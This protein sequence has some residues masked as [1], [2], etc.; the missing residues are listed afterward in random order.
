MQKHLLCCSWCRSVKRVIINAEITG[1]PIGLDY[2]GRNANNQGKGFDSLHRRS[3]DNKLFYI[4]YNKC[5]GGYWFNSGVRYG[6]VP[7]IKSK[8]LLQPSRSYG[9]IN[10]RGIMDS[11]TLQEIVLIAYLLVSSGV[12]LGF[13]MSGTVEQKA[14]AGPIASVVACSIMGIGWV[15]TIPALTTLKLLD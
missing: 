15:I 8:P 11:M 10:K 13:Y 3:K 9:S 14:K 1:R 12:T 5:R 7:E 6:H 4:S 2:L